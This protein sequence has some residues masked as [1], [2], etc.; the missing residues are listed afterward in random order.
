MKDDL[1]LLG[2]DRSPTVNQWV[3]MRTYPNEGVKGPHVA[4]CPTRE[5]AEA[6][7]RLLRA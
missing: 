7:L 4:A 2:P 3:V 6:A 1:I 5:A